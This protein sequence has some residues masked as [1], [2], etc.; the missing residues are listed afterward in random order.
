M[1]IFRMK[2]YK[3]LPVSKGI[4]IG[5]V[6]KYSRKRTLI[7]SNYIDGEEVASELN[8]FRQ[9]REMAHETLLLIKEKA[10]KDLGESQAQIFDAY[11]HMLNDPVFGEQINELIRE[12]RLNVEGAIQKALAELAEK[13]K[14][15]NNNYF[16]ERLRDI[17]DVVSY[18]LRALH[19]TTNDLTNL[20]ANSIIVAEELTPSEIALLD[21][22]LVE[23]FILRQGGMTS[24]TTIV[25]RSLSIPAIINVDTRLLEELRNGEE[26][27]LDAIRGEVIVAPEREV[28][29]RYRKK[30]SIFKKKE[31]ELL[32]LRQEES[33]TRDGYRIRLAANINSLEEVDSVLRVNGDGIGLLRTEFLFRKKDHLFDEERQFKI[34]KSIVEKIGDKPV[35]IRL[36]DIGGDKDLPYFDAP[37][38]INP[39]LGWRGIRVALE[40]QDI[41]KTQL[42][43]LLRASHYGDLRIL[44]PFISSIE[45]LREVKGIIIEMENELEQ[46]NIPYN[47]NIKIGLMIEIPSTAIMAETF[48]REVDFFSIGT[49]D[50]IQYTIAV[51]RNNS[52]IASLYTP[53]HPAVMKLIYQVVKAARHE[54]IGV[55]VCGEAAANKY[56]LPVFVAM[57]ISELSMSSG[58]ILESKKLIRKLKKEDLEEVL[59]KV[60]EMSQAVEIENYLKKIMEA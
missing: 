19:G 16:Q 33:I 25:A 37:Q 29:E 51:D 34:Y 43:A 39:F 8:R 53:F 9:A 30:I 15:L 2:S 11:I 24:H 45:E 32:G 6:Y 7:E 13:F 31:E 18:I 23:G 4:V 10:S 3:G 26:V 47:R 49:N 40:R 57:G 28:L 56:L 14:R 22:D 60:L 42:R 5:K 48:A 27:I 35:V 21:K 17:E 54:K 38:E 41:F 12:E 55:S 59:D 1:V 58:Y 44:I 20:P 50:L 52:K 46:E 36:L